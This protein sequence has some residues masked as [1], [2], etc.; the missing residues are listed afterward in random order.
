MHFHCLQHDEFE[1][2]AYITEW[3]NI[4][5]HNL[6]FTY[7]IKNDQLPPHSS[8]DVLLIM[9]GP[10]G[11]YDEDIFPWLKKE[12]IYIKEAIDLNKK[13]IGI[14]LGC[15]LLAAA[16]G[17]KVYPHE[18]KE[19]GFFPVK[20]VGS[21]PVFYNFP[22]SIIVFHWHGDTFDLPKNAQLIFSSDVCANQAFICNNNVLGL[23]FHLEI[24][25]SLIHS[26]LENCGNEFDKSR[27]TQ[28][29]ESI[30]DGLKY[31]PTCN[32][33][34]DDLLTRFISL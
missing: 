28:K 34:L 21:H 2:P 3:I 10:M 9:G 5:G 18:E 1:K 20:K 29:K 27:Y 4:N 11:A 31:V 30:I 26:W 8:Y 32:L 23:Q 13:V 16:M 19:I 6:T 24:N 12:K 14:C 15:Q 25:K 33:L 7:F 17:S 22:E